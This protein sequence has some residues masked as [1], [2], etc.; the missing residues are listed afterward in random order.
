MKTDKEILLEILDLIELISESNTNDIRRVY[1]GLTTYP[2]SFN[3][4]IKKL[5]KK[6]K[7]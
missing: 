2:K 7:E 6:I 5:R 4:E 1:K 3:D